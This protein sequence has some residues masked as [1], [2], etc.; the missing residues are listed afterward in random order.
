MSGGYQAIYAYNQEIYGSNAC[1]GKAIEFRADEA[2][3]G[4]IGIEKK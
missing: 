4:G 3:F 1:Y 2:K